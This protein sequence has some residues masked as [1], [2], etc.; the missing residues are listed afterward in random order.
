MKFEILDIDRDT[1]HFDSHEVEAND[2]VE[3][4][5]S[6]FDDVDQDV[7]D[8]MKNNIKL[9]REGEW[10]DNGDDEELYIIRLKK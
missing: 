6:L 1:G 5:A 4:L 9:I 2:H 7:L 3:A 8:Q 10:I